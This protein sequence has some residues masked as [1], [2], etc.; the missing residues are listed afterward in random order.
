MKDMPAKN[1]IEHTNGSVSGEANIRWRLGILAA[2]AMTLLSLYPQVQ[3]WLSHGQHWK[4]AI[5][6][7][8]GLGDEVAYAAYVNA[9]IEGRPRRNDPY[10]GR[11]DQLNAPQPESLFSIQFIPAYAIALPARALGLSATAAFIILAPLMALVSSLAVFWLLVSVT[12][13]ERVAAV[14]VIVVLCLGALAT[15]EG[16]FGTLTATN[17]H[18]D[19]FPFLR[20]YQPAASFPLFP[21]FCV[22]VWRLLTQVHHRLRTGLFAGFIF[23][24][25]VFSYFYLWT[26]A[27]AWLAALSVVWMVARAGD[28]K[29]VMVSL[30]IIGAVVIV[31]LL[32]YAILISQSRVTEGVQVLVHSRRPDVF[33][34]TELIGV[35]LLVVI[36]VGVV[37]RR[38]DLSDRRVIFAV[39]FALLPFIVL[40][41]Q[42]ISGRVM[43]P[44]H[45][46]GFIANYS[47]LIAIVISLGL[48]WHTRSGERWQ[49]S[50]RALAWVAIAALEW[51][52]IETYQ[53]AK[54]SVHANNQAAAD[55]A[56][57]VRL[58]EQVRNTAGDGHAETVLFSD[59]RTADG[60]PA[61]SPLSVLWAPHMLVFTGTTT[62][63]SKERLYKQLYYTGFGANELEKYFN[64]SEVYYGY[65][66]GIFGF[67]RIIDG[68]NPSAKPI[69]R[70]E[71][72]TEVLSYVHY[73]A[74][75]NSEHASNPELSYL[76]TPVD[77]AVNLSNLDRWYERDAGERVGDCML[78]H[79]KLRTEAR[80]ES[81]ALSDELRTHQSAMRGGSR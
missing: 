73:L 45:Y 16:T 14:G 78:Y 12:E 28:R 51:G 50:P 69:S 40:N 30:T 29:R 38:I 1:K 46:K 72:D 56:L 19:Y 48:D 8:Q 27:L 5:A 67:D 61:A 25:L 20:R 23:G 35:G 4:N 3:L 68:L 55:M 6:Y 42:I 76:V 47:V 39:A 37:R 11:V 53:A 10:T 7:N 41:Q 66:A 18:F 59:P 24:L 26:A 49:L 58:N 77:G 22:L 71:L 33:S 44:I 17:T 21:I 13:N 43:Q 70:Y 65:A 62:A 34:A 64:T 80:T 31:A 79:V 81:I 52:S 74:A 75:F 15:A 32:P 9:L 54:T 2:F 57:Y 60:A 63:E 36:C